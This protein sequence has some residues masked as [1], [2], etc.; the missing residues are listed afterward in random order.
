MKETKNESKVRN[1]APDEKRDYKT[2]KTCGI[3]WKISLTFF[4][5]LY[6]TLSRKAI[7]IYKK[8]FEEISHTTSRSRIRK[9]GGKKRIF[10][11]FDYELIEEKPFSFFF[12]LIK[13]CFSLRNFKL[14]T[15]SEVHWKIS[16]LQNTK[17][18]WCFDEKP[19]EVVEKKKC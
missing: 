16:R 12:T 2:G 6:L 7:K 1:K 13:T 18:N 9:N 10:F 3:S 15:V 14:L 8:T 17:K 11:E 19:K 5:S 4:L